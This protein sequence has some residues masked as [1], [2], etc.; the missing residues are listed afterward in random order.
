M[1]HA[2]IYEHLKEQQGDTELQAVEPH[3]TDDLSQGG[4]RAVVE[5]TAARTSVMENAKKVTINVVRY[6]KMS[7]RVIFK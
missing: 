6:G 5:F 1:A 3:F 7:S 2:Q 4:R